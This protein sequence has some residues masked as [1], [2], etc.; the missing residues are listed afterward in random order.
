VATAGFVVVG[1][2]T[3]CC[4]KRGRGH[5][6][7]SV[8]GVTDVDLYAVNTNEPDPSEWEPWDGVALWVAESPRRAWELEYGPHAEYDPERCTVA[9]VDLSKERHVMTMA[10]WIDD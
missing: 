9:K 4:Q 7:R 6:A 1:F 2:P 10:P 3:R 5:C 8:S